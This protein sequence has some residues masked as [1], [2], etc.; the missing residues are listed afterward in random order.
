MSA[1]FGETANNVIELTGMLHA[2][3]WIIDRFKKDEPATILCDAMYVV[4]GCNEW[5]NSW[6]R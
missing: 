4:K 5:R 6:K 1:G 3:Q 2:I